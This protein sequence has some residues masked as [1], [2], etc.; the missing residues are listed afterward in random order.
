ME[1]NGKSFNEW[2]E[3]YLN[4]EGKGMEWNEIKKSCLDV[5]K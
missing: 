2:N 3:M 5:L 1:W 4:R